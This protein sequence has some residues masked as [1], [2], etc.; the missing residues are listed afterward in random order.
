MKDF[1]KETRSICKGL[2]H[3]NSIVAGLLGYLSCKKEKA[4][5]ELTPVFRIEGDFTCKMA[6]KL[7]KGSRVPFFEFKFHLPKG[8]G[9]VAAFYDAFIKGELDTAFSCRKVHG[10]AHK[11][12]RHGWNK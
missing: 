1:P 3:F 2:G 7:K 12:D 6:D 5:F 10:V 11:S 8:L 4:S 9:T